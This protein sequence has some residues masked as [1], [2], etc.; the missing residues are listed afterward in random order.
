MGF[1]FTE[2]RG[3]SLIWRD[4]RVQGERQCSCMGGRCQV[5][6]CVQESRPRWPLTSILFPRGMAPC[7]SS[8]TPQHSPCGSILPLCNV[9][10][11]GG[12]S[13]FQ[14]LLYL[15]AFVPVPGKLLWSSLWSIPCSPSGNN[16]S[17]TTFLYSDPSPGYWVRGSTLLPALTFT[18]VP[19]TLHH[20]CWL[21]CPFPL[22]WGPCQWPFYF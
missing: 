7:T 15:S 3:V 11:P 1:S 8:L 22:M 16:P 21:P 12:P 14:L 9:S 4:P 2:E 10:K 17:I 5:P 19:V 13:A 6:G 18:I 20:N